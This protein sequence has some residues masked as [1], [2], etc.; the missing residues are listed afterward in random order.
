MVT[1]W[2]FMDHWLR[3]SQVSK[4]RP[5][6]PFAFFRHGAFRYG[7][8]DKRFGGKEE[9]ESCRGVHGPKTDSSNVRFRQKFC[10]SPQRRVPRPPRIIPSERYRLVRALL[11]RPLRDPARRGETTYV[12]TYNYGSGPVWAE[13]PVSASDAQVRS[14]G[15]HGYDHWNR[16]RH[17]GASLF[18]LLKL[19]LWLRAPKP[20]RSGLSLRIR[21]AT[22]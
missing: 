4:A 13:P 12:A 14:T 3:G 22:T 17:I 9:E 1:S 10:L 5:G 8:S 21:L 20:A 18:V 7:L 6:A 11:C 16:Q 2:V 15:E 19:A